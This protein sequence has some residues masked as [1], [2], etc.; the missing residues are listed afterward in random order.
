MKRRQALRF[1][2]LATALLMLALGAA[3]A[4]AQTFPAGQGTLNARVKIAVQGC[5]KVK[6][7]GPVT[8]TVDAAGVFV[9]DPLN[10]IVGSLVPQG[11]SG[12]VFSVTFDT[13]NTTLIGTLLA[14]YA[15]QLCNDTYA[16]S[17]LQVSASLKLNKRST[18]AVVRQLASFSGTT[19]TG[20]HPGSFKSKDKG[21]WALQ[22]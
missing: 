1:D 9:E 22:P 19:S 3:K 7:S 10:P 20:T 16:M 21:A 11:S 5:D 14:G 12:R 2:V 8:Y 4:S 6:D 17:S 15:G 18:R 13:T